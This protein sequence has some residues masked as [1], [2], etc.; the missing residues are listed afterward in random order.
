MKLMALPE[1]L[2][3]FKDIPY[4]EIKKGLYQKEGFYWKSTVLASSVIL[5]C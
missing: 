1:P 4:E 5:E 2:E 3:I